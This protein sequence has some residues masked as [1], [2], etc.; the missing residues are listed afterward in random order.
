MSRLAIRAL[1]EQHALKAAGIN[2]NLFSTAL[3]PY[4]TR[5]TMRVTIVLSA[6]ATLYV[7]ITN[8]TSLFRTALN[9]GRP[10]PGGVI[11]SFSFGCDSTYTYNLQLDQAVAV[12]HLLV[13]EIVGG[14]VFDSTQGN[15]TSA[16]ADAATTDELPR[17]R[18]LLEHILMN[19]EANAPLLSGRTL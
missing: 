2:A 19:Q 4:E 12:Q 11:K 10:I 15:V 16:A 5:S 18:Q 13:E 14:V 17:I 7:T 9:D 8:G 3:A 1:G 6:P